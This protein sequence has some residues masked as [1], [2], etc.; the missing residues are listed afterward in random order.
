MK[1]RSDRSRQAV[2][3]ACAGRFAG[4]WSLQ[5]TRSSVRVL[6]RFA[7]TYFLA[8][9]IGKN[10]SASAAM[11]GNKTDA[12]KVDLSNVINVKYD[13]IPEEDRQAF[14]AQLKQ[15]EEE[16]I[17]NLLSC[18]G[19]TRNEVVKKAEFSMPSFQSTS[20]TSN[21][22]ALPQSMFD[23]FLSEFGKKLED[24]QKVT[25]DMLFNLSDRMDK[26][27]KGKAVDHTYS[28]SNLT[29]NPSVATAS[30]TEVEYSISL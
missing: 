7:S 3:P 19:R 15:Q 20:S 10:K 25:Q 23:L 8:T 2:W 27:D 30:T 17:K 24:S 21:V 12:S 11:A 5:S 26:I 1:D 14:E 13:D 29:P 18:Y 9:P 16:A 6:T 22:S 28:T 4:D